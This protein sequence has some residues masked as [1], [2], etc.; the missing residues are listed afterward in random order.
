[1]YRSALS[2]LREIFNSAWESLVFQA[3]CSCFGRKLLD[4]ATVWVQI[5][6][7]SEHGKIIFI[8]FRLLIE[9]AA[10]HGTDFLVGMHWSCSG[11]LWMSIGITS[12]FW[13]NGWKQKTRQWPFQRWAVLSFW[14]L[15]LAGMGLGYMY[16]INWRF[17]KIREPILTF[18]QCFS[19]K[20]RTS[21]DP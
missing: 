11:Y 12:R 7:Q 18:D 14:N 20:H 21:V 3:F 8:L 5:W 1:M 9:I 2:S 13:C 17:S 15:E 19:K 4:A 6:Q 16:I 10:L